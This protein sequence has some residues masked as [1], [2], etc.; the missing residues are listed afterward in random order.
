[1]SI[2][3]LLV[4]C[5]RIKGFPKVESKIHIRHAHDNT[6]VVTQIRPTG[7]AVRFTGM[8]YDSWFWG[9]TQEDKRSKYME[10]LILINDK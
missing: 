6:G 5:G 8:K 4:E 1:M 7:C 10:D 3:E 2:E 9:K